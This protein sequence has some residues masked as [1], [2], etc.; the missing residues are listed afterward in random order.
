MSPPVPPG[1]QNIKTTNKRQRRKFNRNHSGATARRT[2]RYKNAQQVERNYERK[3]V[4][5]L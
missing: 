1:F 4:L 5:C 3:K 2:F